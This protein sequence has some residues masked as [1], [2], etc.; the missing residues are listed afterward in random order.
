MPQQN[1]GGNYDPEN[2]EDLKKLALIVEQSPSA[3]L[4][5]DRNGKIEFANK[6]HSILS[7]YSFEEIRGKNVSILNSRHQGK[8]IYNDLWSILNDG[9]DWSG[10]FRNQRKDGEPYWVLASITPYYNSSGEITHFISIQEDISYLKKI[11]LELK[12]SEEKFR[13]LFETLPEGIVVTDMDGYILQINQA[14]LKIHR[15]ENRNELIGKNIRNVLSGDNP[16]FIE[17]LFRQAGETGYSMV[18]DYRLPYDEPVYVDIQV[19]LMKGEAHGNMGFVVLTGDITESKMAEK[20]LK[21]SEARNRALVEAVPDIMFRVNDEG[22]YLDK[23]LGSKIN[24]VFPQEV[25]VSTV[26]YISEAIKTRTIQI[27]EYPVQTGGGSE[28]YEARFVAIE[29]DEVLVILRNVTERK[30]AMEAIE[31]ARKEAELA[32]RAKSEFLANMSHEIRTPLNSITG[33]I[34][35][36]MRSR[37]ND[38]QRDYLGII[39]K[40][41][42]S[43][44]GIINDILDFS[45]IESKHMEINNVE[46]NPYIEFESVV[47]LYN[48]KAREKGIVFLSFI[49][50]ELPSGIISDPLR[51]KQILGNLLSNAIKFTPEA[52]FVRIDIRLVYM[53]EDRC[54]IYFMVSDTG[55]GIPLRKQTSIFEAFAQADS[56]ITR[57]FGGTGLGLSIS[58]NLARLL[59]SEIIIE[60]ETGVGSRFFLSLEPGISDP[61][62]LKESLA[63]ERSVNIYL[64]SDDKAADM[65]VNNIELYLSG[66]GCIFKRG[67]D[68]REFTGDYDLTIAVFSEK[69]H[70]FLINNPSARFGNPPILIAGSSDEVRISGILKFFKG[71]LFH[72]LAPDDIAELIYE[73]AGEAVSKE[74]AQINAGFP[75]SLKFR[76]DVLVGEDDKTNQ[77]LIRLLL[78]DYG[79]SSDIA[80]NGLDVFDRFK[81]KKYDLVLMDMHMPVADG[82]ETTQM[83]LEYEKVNQL[84]HTPVVALTAKAIQGDEEL[85]LSSG[86]D[87]YLTK[88]IEIEK[89]EEVFSRYLK[90]EKRTVPSG[91]ADSSSKT[92]MGKQRYNIKSVAAEL[93]IPEAV[94]INVAGEFL[95]DARI[96]ISELK[97]MMQNLSLRD[98]YLCVHKLKGAAANLRFENL[99]LFFGE[100]EENSA[101]GNKE[102]DYYY[103][104]NKIEEELENIRSNFLLGA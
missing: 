79:I 88:P 9:E 30:K 77:K 62:S 96:E 50:P 92:F 47:S 103:I 58:A 65:V 11:E 13:V 52:G 5:T 71:V 15:H 74:T 40:S 66:F 19:S 38:S 102:F 56:S 45:K 72:P 29:D 93:K 46:F 14:Y 63:S 78:A 41:A 53:M 44:L 28:H 90:I 86:M 37:L 73:Q 94:L 87:G 39:K 32:N 99:T 27:F 104:I 95:N 49:D 60:S 34:E 21:E 57:R 4:I 7:G 10:E 51:I 70:E 89:L 16:L 23:M 59:E 25:A 18:S 64:Y 8:E 98:V 33:F 76:G 61:I 1:S 82:I 42:A 43:L 80:G 3:V 84:N 2:G 31:E 6:K 81:N 17:K 100:I 101:N 12:Q 54:L 35:L 83:I 68:I 22:I 69:L 20:A 55:I 67:N 91:R 85:I 97:Q 48:I 24:E 26:K 36:L 75:Q